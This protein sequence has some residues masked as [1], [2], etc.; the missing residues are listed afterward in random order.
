M[1]V[2]MLLL[3][4]SQIPYPLLALG[5]RDLKYRALGPSEGAASRPFKAAAM[6][7]KSRTSLFSQGRIGVLQRELQGSF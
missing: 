1:Y 2:Y 4:P 3:P 7:P 5:T 6:R